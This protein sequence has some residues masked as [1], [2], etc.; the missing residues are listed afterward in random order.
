MKSIRIQAALFTLFMA[1]CGGAFA[2]AWPS[3]PVRIIVPVGAGTFGDI[4]ARLVSDE[5]QAVFRQPFTVENKAGASGIIAAE[6]VA[7]SAPDGYTLLIMTNS[8]HSANPHLFKKLPYEPVK[9]FTAIARICYVPFLLVVAQDSPIDSL[10]DLVARAK[11]NPGKLTYGYGNTTGQVAAA[12]FATL[13]GVN[14]VAVPYKTTPQAMTEV[15]GGRVDFLFTDAGSGAA[16][17]KSGRLR[18][19]AVTSEKRSALLPE[20][21]TVEEGARLPGYS[22]AAWA[23]LGAPAGLSGDIAT[24]IS[25][26][27]L[28]LTRRRNFAEKLH[29]MGAEPAPAPVAEFNAYLGRQLE[30]WGQKI[31][32]AGIEPQ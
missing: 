21:P 13:A 22:V 12:A 11:T 18:A 31:K 10:G 29:A 16:L 1:A 17:L 24:K 28:D 5:L 7:K 19:I 9:D 4:L 23:G 30:T 26:A 6:F 27:L 20:V 2:Q 25:N 15:V 14:L 32:E 3:R 8:A